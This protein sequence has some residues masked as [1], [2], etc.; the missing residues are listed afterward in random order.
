VSDQEPSY[1]LNVSRIFS[2]PREAVYRAF[3]DPGQLSEWL[4]PAGWSIGPDQVE[5]DP[6]PGGQ[7]SYTATSTRDP[8]LRT[9]TSAEFGR[10]SEGRLFACSGEI[11][12]QPAAA[13]MARALAIA[14]HDERGGA[15]RLELRAGPYTEAGEIDAREFW[16]LAFGRL[17][18]LLEHMSSAV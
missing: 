10:V 6:K 15:T 5:I 2:A 18:V 8:T 14:L 13:E 7:L 17:D 11:R 4:A 1:Q 3:T 16:N 9:A 12:P